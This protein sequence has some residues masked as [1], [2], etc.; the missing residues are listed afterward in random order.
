MINRTAPGFS[1]DL[2]KA[3]LNTALFACCRG[4]WLDLRR[5][6]GGFLL[7][8]RRLRKFGSLLAVQLSDLRGLLMFRLLP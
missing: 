7:F 5:R 2:E 1:K 3:H 4:C 6:A 8:V